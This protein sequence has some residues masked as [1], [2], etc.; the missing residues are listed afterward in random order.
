[1]RITKQKRLL[2]ET[3]SRLTSFFDAYNLHGKVFQ[4]D[5]RI[6]IATVYRFLKDLESKGEIHSYLCN[7]HKIYSS[8]KD[9]HIHFTCEKCGTVKHITTKK[10]DFLQEVINDQI[11][12]FQID[13]TGICKNCS[14]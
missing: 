1:M 12:H 4:S 2:Q 14:K 3:V 6:G 7:N 10:V 11:C 9:N 8:T 5:K 13:V